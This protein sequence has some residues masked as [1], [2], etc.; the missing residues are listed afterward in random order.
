MPNSA[1]LV[2]VL[3]RC[4]I[5]V[6]IFLLGRDSAEPRFA[7]SLFLFLQIRAL[8]QHAL[9]FAVRHLH[10]RICPTRVEVHR[11]A[12]TVCAFRLKH[13]GNDRRVP[14]YRD[15]NILRI[16][17]GELGRL[18]VGEKF[19]TIADRSIRVDVD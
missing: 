7:A 13:H 8:R 1:I 9:P 17:A 3:L 18:R 16:H 6:A 12:L 5:L 14:K 11:L 15:L 2:N 19:R 10:P 4:H